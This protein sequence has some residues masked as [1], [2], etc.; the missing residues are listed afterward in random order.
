MFSE[1]VEFNVHAMEGPNGKTHTF[2]VITCRGKNGEIAA[3]AA[4]VPRRAVRCSS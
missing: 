3:V 2:P 1:T 4:P